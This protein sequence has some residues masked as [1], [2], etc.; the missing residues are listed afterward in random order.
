V[1]DARIVSP[2]S[3]M[4]QHLLLS[5]P[6]NKDIMTQLIYDYRTNPVHYPEWQEYFRKYQPPT[7]IAWGAN[8]EIFPA[9][10]ARAYL[11]DLPK[12]ELHLLETGHFALEEKGDEIASLMRDF[13]ARNATAQQ[14][15]K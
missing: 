15:R 11:R 7:L 2:D 1:K 6:G 8:D 4:L 12:A 5:R 9:A 14:L 3:W 13:L 10:G